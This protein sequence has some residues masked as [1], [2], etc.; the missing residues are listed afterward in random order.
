MIEVLLAQL[1]SPTVHPGE[2]K[3]P[4]EE[5]IRNQEKVKEEIDTSEINDVESGSTE[6]SENSGNEKLINGVRLKGNLIY[7]DDVLSSIIAECSGKKNLA[8][9]YRKCAV[10]L[11]T[12]YAA[13]GY[14]T[15]KAYD[16]V[17]SKGQYILVVPGRISEVVVKSGKDTIV[18]A[19]RPYAYG[20]KNK[21]LNTRD[22]N[23]FLSL[24][25]NRVAGIG[26]VNAKL[27]RLGSERTKARLLLDIKEQASR[28]AGKVEIG[29]EGKAG[30]GEFDLQAVVFKKDAFKL[31]DTLLFFN[32]EYF[33]RNIEVGQS[34]S[35]LSYK[36]PVNAQ[37][38]LTSGLSFTRQFEPN[39]QESWDD[40]SSR[41]LQYTL[42]IEVGLNRSLE[43]R[44]VFGTSIVS[45]SGKLLYQ[46]VDLP[47]IVPGIIKNQK[48]GY[49]QM[50]VSQSGIFQ[51]VSTSS[52]VYF[53]KALPSM[54]PEYQIEELKTLGRSLDEAN[55][56]G[57][58]A[59]IY[60]R[61]GDL[62]SNSLGAFGQ[63]ALGRLS[64]PMRFTLGSGLGLKGLPDQFISGDSG[65]GI[66][67]KSRIR[68][69]RNKNTSL[70]VSPYVGY[71]FVHTEIGDVVL[72]DYLGS[73][74]MFLELQTKHGVGI[75]V[76][77]LRTLL[78][79]DLKATWSDWMLGNGLYA[80]MSYSF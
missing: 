50:E 47:E 31:G 42:G 11:S 1:V 77:Y 76:G 65:W 14:I 75:E 71:G 39:T 44:V 70:Y 34:V 3:F 26:V 13:D 20:L 5:S 32:E 35:S 8:R 63:Y 58:S 37:L 41:Q 80:R 43:N 19:V 17:D 62:V 79:E 64:E 16:L 18:E 25:K 73:Y 28:V 10:V 9:R 7:T 2:I 38:S 36:Y 66:V 24:L 6:N 29:N 59:L 30:S 46:G 53:I 4:A 56:I 12:R 72:E 49:M 22:L 15:T 48:A 55:A 40:F 23:R 68:I 57:G 60:Q 54:T 27:S 61:Y 74:G 78:R 52:R 51:R 69:N 67:G 33:G 45:Q 21:V